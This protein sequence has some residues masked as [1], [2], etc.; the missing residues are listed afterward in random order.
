MLNKDQKI[1]LDSCAVLLEYTKNEQAKGRLHRQGAKGHARNQ[2]IFSNPGV[3][4]S[5]VSG[6]LVRSLLELKK[7]AW[8]VR[9]MIHNTHTFM[10]KTFCP[11]GSSNSV[12]GLASC[13]RKQN[14]P[15]FA[16]GD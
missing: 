11:P 16:F 4:L 1:L 7:S 10:T 9:Q 15:V 2:V 12:A 3:T 5:P 14:I 8:Q 6:G 13:I